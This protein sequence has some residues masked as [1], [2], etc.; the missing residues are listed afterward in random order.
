MS[1]SRLRE[2]FELCDKEGRGYISPKRF[3]KMIRIFTEGRLKPSEELAKI[4]MIYFSGVPHLDFTHF[5]NWW[6]HPKKFIMFSDECS[7]HLVKAYGIYT[8][9]TDGDALSY[10]QM[11]NLLIEFDIAITQSQFDKLD[12]NRDGHLNFREFWDWLKWCD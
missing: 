7:A 2:A 5:S 10:K 4:I 6:N 1:H 8:T 12:K 11:K 3:S 9:Y